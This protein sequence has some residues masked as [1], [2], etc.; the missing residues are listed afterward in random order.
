MLLQ[1][2]LYFGAKRAFVLLAPI[3]FQPDNDNNINLIINE[4]QLT[5]TVL[6]DLF[7]LCLAI[8][9]ADL[10][11]P[12]WYSC[13]WSLL[14]FFTWNN[15]LICACPTLPLLKDPAQARKKTFCEW[16]HLSSVHRKV[17]FEVCS[18]KATTTQCYVSS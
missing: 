8:H 18:L 12:W 5:A 7:K 14:F 1:Y 15:L 16:P 6:R 3:P 2:N 4:T 11:D 17:S 9:A 10:F 13:K